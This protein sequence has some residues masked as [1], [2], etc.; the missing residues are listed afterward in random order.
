[1]LKK[2]WLT[3]G[4]FLILITLANTGCAVIGAAASAGI[5]YAIYQATKK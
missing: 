5:G 3:T 2:R 1:M 4:I